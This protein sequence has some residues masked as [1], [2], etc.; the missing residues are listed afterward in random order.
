MACLFILRLFER[1][2]GEVGGF[3]VSQAGDDTAEVALL[4]GDAHIDIGQLVV[5][6]DLGSLGYQC[7]THADKISETSKKTTKKYSKVC[8]IRIFYVTLHP[9]SVRNTIFDAPNSAKLPHSQIN[10]QQ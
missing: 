6:E 7:I 1:V 10:E 8:Q 9:H 4:V 2:D 5:V 3:A